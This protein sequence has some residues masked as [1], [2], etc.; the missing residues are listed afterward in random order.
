MEEKR[1]SGVEGGGLG[2]REKRAGGRRERRR[3]RS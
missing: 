3:G 1:E 2:R